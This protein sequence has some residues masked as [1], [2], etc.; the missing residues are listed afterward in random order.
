MTSTQ[1]KNVT[2]VVVTYNPDILRLSL[3]CQAAQQ[4]TGQIEI[5]DNGSVDRILLAI[6]KLAAESAGHIALHELGSNQGI[7]AAQNVGIAVARQRNS[8]YVLLLDH[9][10]IP[11]P[12]MVSK[13]LAAI[14]DPS[15]HGRPIAAVGPRYTDM[16][17]ESNSAPFVR[18]EGSRRVRCP[19]EQ[20]DQRMEVEHLIASGC[21][22]SMAALNDIGDMNEALFIDYVDIEWCLRAT[23]AGYCLLGVCDA[24]MQHRLGEAGKEFLGRPISQHAPLR[25]FYM[26]RNA[27]LLCRMPHV[28]RQWK[29]VETKSLVFRA[30]ST[31][32]TQSPRLSYM[33]MI[34]QGLIDGL[35]GKQ[36]PR[37]A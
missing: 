33:K 28:S 31:L 2:T 27:L 4:Q 14:E 32:A 35:R 8:D 13:L 36:G 5:V 34:A 16:G 3:L 29:M 19:C 25:N 12:D 30:V 15:P 20:P 23:H 24:H 9:D 22:I 1:G 26:F 37:R 18:L 6:R 7:G 21:L 10:S 11:E 17:H